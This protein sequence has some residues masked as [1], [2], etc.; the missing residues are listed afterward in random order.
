MYMHVEE[1]EGSKH[2]INIIG[3]VTG[4]FSRFARPDVAQLLW[5][6]SVDPADYRRVLI[7]R[8]L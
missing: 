6:P 5:R 4:L 1:I 3:S 7:T 8:Y 2:Y